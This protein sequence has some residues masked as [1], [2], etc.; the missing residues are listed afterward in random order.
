ME[1]TRSNIPIVL[2]NELLLF[3]IE[4]SIVTTVTPRYNTVARVHKFKIAL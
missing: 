2:D 3:F 1:V 4:S